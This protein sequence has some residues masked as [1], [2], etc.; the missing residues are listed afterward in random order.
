MYLTDI[1]C[2]MHQHYSRQN[3]S[4]ADQLSLLLKTRKC[5]LHLQR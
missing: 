5:Y 2:L 3:H 4:Q 1:Y